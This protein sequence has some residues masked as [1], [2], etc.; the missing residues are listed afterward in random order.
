MSKEIDSING[1]GMGH[2]NGENGNDYEMDDSVGFFKDHFLLLDVTPSIMEE[3][4]TAVTHPV[5]FQS[6]PSRSQ[7]VPI[8]PKPVEVEGNETAIDLPYECHICGKKSNTRNNHNGHLRIHQE[9]LN[10]KCT[11]CG[12]AF[13]TA[14]Y[15]RNHMT[16][17]MDFIDNFG[18]EVFTH[19]NSYEFDF[20]KS[21]G[22]GKFPCR[23]CPS[24]FKTY[25]GLTTHVYCYHKGGREIRGELAKSKF[26]PTPTKFPATE[27]DT[28]NQPSP[29]QNV[30]L[31]QVTLES[32]SS[33]KQDSLDS[34]LIARGE[35]EST[36]VVTFSNIE[37]TAGNGLVTLNGEGGDMK[38]AKFSPKDRP[39]R[40]KICGEK[41]RGPDNLRC[42]P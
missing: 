19:S 17:S 31:E 33:H 2:E 6:S 3:P 42:V 28:V 13:K 16:V 37:E 1:V 15:L 14:N 41:C 23:K 9:S 35:V 10:H 24:R 7:F 26:H 29:R 40:C 30:T 38:K 32:K 27:T 34:Q 39:I 20:Q 4:E 18:I 12:Q 21:H 25:R 5:A 22:G 8:L 11:T 36:K